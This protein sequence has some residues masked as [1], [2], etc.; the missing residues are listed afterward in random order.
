MENP[1][2]IM[3]K[4]IS[5]YTRLLFNLDYYR[6]KAAIINT[7]ELRYMIVSFNI[8]EKCNF[9]IKNNK[10]IDWKNNKIL[11]ELWDYDSSREVELAIKLYLKWIKINLRDELLKINN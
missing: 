11:F 7:Q 3:F 9:K 10:L 8:F 6:D 4:K 2:H 1:L 5:R